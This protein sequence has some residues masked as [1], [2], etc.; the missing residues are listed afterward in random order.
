MEEAR[1]KNVIICHPEQRNIYNKIFGG[2]LMRK[3]FE[4]AWVNA[5]MYSQCKVEVAVVDDITFKK[6]VTI[7]SLL[8]LSSQ[9]VYTE[10]NSL[11]VKVH[12]EVVDPL[13]SNRDV[14]NEFYFKFNAPNKPLVPRVIPKSY[15][16][17][18]IYLDGRRHW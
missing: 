4:L 6:P 11:L 14:T 12:A 8:F 10:A 13:T 9:V 1:V 18:M 5:C 15:S 7:G 3:G 2:F 17:A 16:E